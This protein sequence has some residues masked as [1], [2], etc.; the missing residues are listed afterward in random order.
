MID[1]PGLNDNRAYDYSKHPHIWRSEYSV[2]ADWLPNDAKVIDLGCGN[3]ALAHYLMHEKS[4]DVV[5]VESS[6]TGV[7]QARSKGIRTYCDPIDRPLKNFKRGEFD[8]AV[9]NVTLQMVMY[10]EVLLDE[11]L[12]ISHRQIISFPNFAFY[13]NRFELLVKGRMPRTQLFG[14][15]WY[16]TG[17]IHQLS[18]EDFRDFIIEKG[19]Q[20]LRLENPDP[21]VTRWKRTLAELLPNLFYRTIVCEIGPR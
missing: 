12:R 20:I 6:T 17:H 5:G 18:Y 3:G 2:I 14:Y 19:S 9:C 7:E 11:M 13:K 8:Y 21:P 16:N 10:P 4:C 1:S 15:S